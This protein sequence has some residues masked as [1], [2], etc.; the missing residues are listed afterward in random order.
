MSKC[1]C[2]VEGDWR[3]I[4]EH[5]TYLAFWGIDDVPFG[6]EPKHYVIEA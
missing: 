5:I 2:G 1:K 6:E 4:E 3:E